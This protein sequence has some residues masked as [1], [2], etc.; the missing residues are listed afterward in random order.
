AFLASPAGG[1]KVVVKAI[2]EEA[3]VSWFVARDTISLLR[4]VIRT[5]QTRYLARSAVPFAVDAP[6]ANVPVHYSFW[7]SRD[8]H[9]W[10]PAE[11]EAHP[12][13]FQWTPPI[14]GTNDGYFEVM[15]RS[16]S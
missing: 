5:S 6:P 11:V 12:G 10:V 15:A 2:G 14:Q 4:P 16:D 9:R 13:G 1:A 3:G 8:P 7:F